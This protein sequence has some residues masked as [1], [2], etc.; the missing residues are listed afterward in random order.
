MVGRLVEQEKRRGDVEGPREADAHAPAAA[1]ALCWPRL[2]R[3]AEPEP[4]ENPGGPRLGCRAPDLVELL[5]DGVQ[6]V[7][8]LVLGPPLAVDLGPVLHGEGAEPVV[9][10]LLLRPEGH[11]LRVGLHDSAE[12]G[13]LISK[14]LLLHQEDVNVVGDGDPALGEELHQG[15]LAHPVG[16]D[17]AISPARHDRQR[18]VLEQQ[19]PLGADRELLDLDVRSVGH[20]LGRL[21]R[22]LKGDIVDI[23]LPHGILLRPCRC[24]RKLSLLILHLLCLLCRNLYL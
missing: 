15:R 5:V 24:L 18:R 23:L 19:L 14:D 2:H 10:V 16:P 1:E 20:L 7:R 6:S 11:H 13:P 21:C 17:K 12:R 3:G 4:M 9:D 8:Q 22:R